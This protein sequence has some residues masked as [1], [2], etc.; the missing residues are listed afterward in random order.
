MEVEYGTGAVL[1]EAVGMEVRVIT[2][3]VPVGEAAVGVAAGGMGA[4]IGNLTALMGAARAGA[5]ATGLVPAA[6]ASITIE[7]GAAG[8]GVLARGGPASPLAPIDE[9][10]EFAPAEVG[11]DASGI[12]G[13]A[14]ETIDAPMGDASVHPMAS[15]MPSATATW[16]TGSQSRDI[17]RSIAE[18]D[19]IVWLPKP[20][21][22]P[23][24][25][26]QMLG[27]SGADV[28]P[29]RPGLPF[30]AFATHRGE[31]GSAIVRA[32]QMGVLEL[33][34]AGA[35]TQGARGAVVYAAS[36]SDFNLT[37]G[38]PIGKVVQVFGGGRCRVFFETPPFRSF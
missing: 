1:A 28:V 27:W 6:P 5:A 33:F 2:P 24:F 8:V 23:I 3:A 29:W 30:A 31:I 10:Y 34:V 22:M 35:T 7:M 37:T 20:R 12:E 38:T 19:S 21:G 4:T 17:G 32:R 26:G 9:L 36:D 11:V 18:P 16:L 15:G 14:L 25:A 13:V